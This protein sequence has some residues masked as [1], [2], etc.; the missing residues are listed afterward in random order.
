MN[1]RATLRAAPLR[2]HTR[3]PLVCMSPLSP[4][5]VDTVAPS[6]PSTASQGEVVVVMVVRG[7]MRSK[8]SSR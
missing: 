3:F 2:Y 4:S 6:G 7:L 8:W 1:A 5:V